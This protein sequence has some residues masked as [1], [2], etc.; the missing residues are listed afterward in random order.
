MALRLIDIEEARNYGKMLEIIET[1]ISKIFSKMAGEKIH[2]PHPTPPGP[3]PGHKLQK[4]LK[5]SGYFSHLPPSVLFLSLK[6]RVKRG[7]QGTMLPPFT[8]LLT[9][10]PSISGHNYKWK[11]VYCCF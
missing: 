11:R 10:L 1:P 8:S 6:G 9:S 4:P 3:A 7:G 5:E 2:I